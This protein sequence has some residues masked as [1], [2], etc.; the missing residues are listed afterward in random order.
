MEHRIAVVLSA[1]R[2][3]ELVGCLEQNSYQFAFYGLSPSFDDGE[4][5]SCLRAAEENGAIVIISAGAAARAIMRLGSVPLVMIRRSS[6]SFTRAVKEALTYTDAIAIACLPGRHHE[7]ALRAQEISA[8]PIEVACIRE[9]SQLSPVVAALKEKGIGRLVG[10]ED[11]VV[12]ARAQGLPAAMVPFEEDDILQAVTEALYMQRLLEDNIQHRKM[13]G[14]VQNCS[15]EGIV[16]LGED[17]RILEIN[18]TALEMMGRSREQMLEQP[19]AD[20]PLGAIDLETTVRFGVPISGQLAKIEGGTV[21]FSTHPVTVGD[22]LTALV[23]TFENVDRVQKREQA[24]RKKLHAKGHVATA[25]FDSIVGESAAIKAVIGV[26]KRYAA[27]DSTVLIHGP[28]GCGKEVFAQSI[29]N[30]SRR[31]SAPFVVINCAALPES[32]LESILFGYEAG[33]FTGARAGGKQGLFELA[34]GGTVFLDEISE[35][36]LNVQA[37]FLRVL[38]EKEIM[39]VGSDNVFPVDVRVLASTNR[40]LP[41]LVAEG[42]FRED[43]FYRIGVLTLTIP[44]LSQRRADIEPL[45]R[46]FLFTRARALG[47]TRRTFTPEALGYIANAHLPGN[48]RQLA[49]LVERAMV[50]SEGEEIDLDTVIGV[51]SPAQQQPPPATLPER[52]AHIEDTAVLEALAQSGGSRVRAA[53]R[54]GMSTSTLWRRL[55]RI[56]ARQAAEGQGL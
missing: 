2:R 23:L 9:Q 4:I 37:R 36:P 53:E 26:A 43:L 17:G 44:P 11:A 51:F 56:E 42:R 50:I 33:S 30:A 5:L 40:D 8:I 7:A 31:K 3:E 25:T 34:G 18:H 22:K 19:V 21:M 12:E 27:V 13:L 32:I 10:Y 41:T 14:I 6:A 52:L 49:N 29:H 1:N 54:L 28:T 47:M 38:Q 46:Y 45:A 15:S 39:P 16:V 55:R 20:T 35:M 24:I 48:V